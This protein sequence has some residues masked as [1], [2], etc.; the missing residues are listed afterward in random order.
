LTESQSKTEVGSTAK[1]GESE[2]PQS[3][4]A[5]VDAPLLASFTHQVINPLNGVVGTI[6]NLIDGTIGQSR[7]DQRLKAVRAQLVHA[8]ELV[9]NLAYLSQI[10]TEAGRQGLRDV[11]AISIV[12]QVVIEAAQFFQELAA[13]RGMKI[14]LEDEI[15]QYQVPGARALLRQVFTNLFENAVKYGRSGTTIR[16]IPRVQSHSNTLIIDVINKGP[17]FDSSEKER[18]FDRGFRGKAAKDLAAS[19][20]GLG[21]YL[22]REI[23]RTAFDATIEAE[24]SPARME[25][26]F[27]MRFA[28][29]SIRGPR[30]G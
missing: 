23:L 25:T 12:P 6:D 11:T 14:L 10:S 26:T 15:T 5:I 20:S 28:R 13:A 29:Y 24:H 19:G 30:N 2:A 18:I 9:R 1:T 21:L 22:S 4:V 3:P 27:R 17:G 7:R 8:I 16:V